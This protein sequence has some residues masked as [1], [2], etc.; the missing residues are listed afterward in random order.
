MLLTRIERVGDSA[1]L[2]LPYEMLKLLNLCFGDEVEVSAEPQIV[3]GMRYD[4]PNPRYYWVSGNPLR[5]MNETNIKYQIGE[6]IVF[7][8][9]FLWLQTFKQVMLH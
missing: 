8:R 7:G 2:L 6:G 9:C 4:F 5:A 3:S 1:A